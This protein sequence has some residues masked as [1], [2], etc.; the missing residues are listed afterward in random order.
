MQDK[1]IVFPEPSSGNKG[2]LHQHQIPRFLTPLIGREQEVRAACAL[3]RRPEVR[4]LTLTGTGGVGK[5]RLGLQIATNLLDDFA[6][7][8]SFV[9]LASINQV[10]LILPT[11]ASALGLRETG[12]YSL[13]KRLA[14]TFG[15]QPLLLVLDNFEQVVDAASALVDLL[16]VCPMLKILVT[17]RAVLHV[18]GAYEF[19]VAPLTL[20]APEQYTNQKILLQSTAVALFLER[21]RSILPDFQIIPENMQA[22]AEICVRLDGLPLAIE[23][24][25]AR[26]RLLSPQALL[27][28]LGRRLDLLTG[29]T[30]DMPERQQTLRKA[31]AWSYDLLTVAEQHLFHLLS[32]FVGGCTLEA[33]SAIANPEHSP[34]S[35][36]AIE[37]LD[38]VT[39][40]VEKSLL[41]QTQQEGA[42]P[43][44]FMLE[45]V[46][47]YGLEC[48]EASGQMEVAR[49]THARYYLHLA[50]EADARLRGP[51]QSRWLERL[52]REHDNLRAVLTWTLASKGDRTTRETALR[53]ATAL[54]DFWEIRGYISEGRVFLEGALAQAEDCEA[55]VRGRA[56]IAA[57]WHAKAQGNFDQAE[58]RG[59]Q[60]LLLFREREESHGIAH[61]LLLLGN[62]AM[63][64]GDNAESRALLEEGLARFRAAS[65]APSTSDVLLVLA[66]VFINLGEY[67]RALTL[68]EENLASLRAAGNILSATEVL[69][70]LAR[71]IFYQGDLARA[72]TLLEECLAL[73][74]QVDYKESIALALITMGLVKLVQGDLYTAR[75]L[76]EE[77]LTLS[78]RGEWGE[79]MAWGIYGLGWVAY[80]EQDYE[81]ART[82]FEE[83]LTLCMTLGN[84]VF[85]A[86][87]LE[88][89]AS[90]VVMQK[91]GAWAAR[92]WGAAAHLRQ[93]LSAATPLFMQSTYDSFIGHLRS[94]LGQEAFTTLWKQ[95]HSMTLKQV[96]IAS[97]PAS[98]QLLA[99]PAD[100]SA[101]SS[102]FAELT[103]REI[104]VLR[105]LATGI[106]NAQIAEQLVL[107]VLT[108]NGHLRSI[109]SKL[110]VTSRSAATRYALEHRLV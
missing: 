64:R 103:P 86:F 93:T 1:I 76:L 74:R 36:Q 105:L 106:T 79:R 99:E 29:A 7:G 8:V 4:L 18:R 15:A 102:A 78:R 73:S 71:T 89:L 28:R 33:V 91:Q 2:Q 96:L 30:Q 32:V 59:R 31:L 23:L 13:L 48:L 104:E 85:I 51:Q 27:A 109:Y 68:L 34:T 3:L 25:A 53:I 16:Q 72:H 82:L 84:K 108:V 35:Q 41:Q 101:T 62:I 66:N 77:G 110:G 47:E 54:Q 20:P 61:S 83:G 50:E 11:I 39:S 40:L 10:A 45:T 92:L 6:A 19:P 43:R 63:T 9:S 24:A 70:L 58:T 81:T 26:S 52:E 100:V 98:S 5:T 65:D 94:Q 90:V 87:H 46:R 88:G 95:G 38:G 22:I 14:T 57:G 56:L 12:E 67:N 60:S 42:E 44:L 49:S 97:E 80:F 17:S 69:N 75:S 107:S 37:I 21:T 55:P